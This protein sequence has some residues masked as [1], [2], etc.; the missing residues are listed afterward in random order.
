M[1]KL[2]I[3]AT[4]LAAI[5]LLPLTTR[6]FAQTATSTVSPV[7]HRGAPGPLLGAGPL[8]LV[9]GVGYG[10]YWLVKRRRRNTTAV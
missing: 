6:T 2:I 7:A 5:T 10:V 8:G 3:A 4:A 1:S 9:I